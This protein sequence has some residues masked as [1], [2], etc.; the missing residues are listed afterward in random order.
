MR[1]VANRAVIDTWLA[2]EWEKNES[3]DPTALSDDE[4][5]DALL[6]AKPGAAAFFWRYAP[7]SCYSLAL[8]KAQFD[9]LHVVPGPDGLGWRALAPTGLVRECA[10]RIDRG[11]PN[12][13]ASDTGIDIH[14]IERLAQSSSPEPL[15]ISTRRGD[16]PWHVADGNHRAVATALALERGARYEPVSAY[17]CAG[18][19]P[20]L[21]P[22][23]E[24][25]RG[26]FRGNR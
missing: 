5:L 8:S 4:A 2:H 3:G 21:R 22:L 10:R 13:L 7:V 20:V 16:V 9:R 1:R 12:A 18:V 23:C 25:I 6:T 24:R 17:L 19:N 11:D 14:A 15:I 26:L